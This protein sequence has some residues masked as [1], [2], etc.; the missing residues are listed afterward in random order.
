MVLIT[1]LMRVSR[2]DV[3]K[4]S[5]PISIDRKITYWAFDWILPHKRESSNLF[6]WRWENGISNG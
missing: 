5:V 6:K 4:D 3:C 1:H 2:N